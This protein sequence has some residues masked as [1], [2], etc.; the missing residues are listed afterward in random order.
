PAID[1]KDRVTIR[2]QGIDAPELHYEPTAPV[3]HGVKP[4]PEQ[5]AAFKAHNGNFRQ[6]FGETAATHLHD[7]LGKAGAS[8][9][10]CVVRT[11]VDEPNDVFDTYGRL[12]GDI[13]V[14]IGGKEQNANKWLCDNGW[15]FPTF[16]ASM[17]DQEITDL[18]ALT[19]PAR[20]AR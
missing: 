19:E 10:T 11:Q 16:Y 2:L 4:T 20:K 8:P 6:F 9:V 5:K 15:A 17:T 18:I 1:S 13:F 12:V 14:T 3:L 7:F